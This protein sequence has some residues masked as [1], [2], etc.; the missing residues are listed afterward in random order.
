[1]AIFTINKGSSD[2][3]VDSSSIVTDCSSSFIYDVEAG[4][5]DIIDVNISGDHQGEYY[6]LDGAK[7]FFTDTVTGIVFLNSFGVGFFLKNSGDAGVFMEATVSIT[8]NNSTDANPTFTETVIRENDNIDCD[9]AMLTVSPG[10]EDNHVAVF[11]SDNNLEG[12][13][14]FTYDGTTLDV[15]GQVLGTSIAIDGG[16]STQYLMADGSLSIGTGAGTGDLNYVHDQPTASA[17]WTVA[18]N[19]GKFPTV[20]VVD[21]AKTVVLGDIDHTDINNL[22]ITF[23]AA[24]SGYAYVN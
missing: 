20:A 17:T 4:Q 1:M 24:F 8:N 14:D 18:H 16:L 6:I 23:N 21:T 2:Y 10:A 19:L 3:S 12:T 22:V 13:S 9:A 7:T 15:T 5:G 11:T